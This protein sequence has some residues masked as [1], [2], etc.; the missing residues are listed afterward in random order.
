MKR[1]MYLSIVIGVS[2]LTGSLGCSQPQPYCA[3]LKTGEPVP[4]AYCLP[5]GYVPEEPQGW[6]RPSA[7]IGMP[8][9][10]APGMD[11]TIFHDTQGMTWCNTTY[12]SEWGPSTT[13][14]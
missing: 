3:N 7:A 6:R 14:Q 10:H 2:L 1:R 8:P 5:L 12:D 13:C 11:T 9:I 4:M